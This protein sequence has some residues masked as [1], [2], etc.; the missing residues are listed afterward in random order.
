MIVKK[1]HHNSSGFGIIEILVVAVIISLVLVGLHSAAVQ[2]LRLIHQSTQRT[3]ATFLLEETVEVLR[4]LRD[5]GWSTSL[6]TLSTGTDYFLSF[7]G[8][9]WTV[10]TTKTLIDNV[11]ERKFTVEDIYRDANDDIATTGTLDPD[12][13]KITVTVLWGSITGES[14]VVAYETGTTDTDLANFPDNSGWGD[15]LQSFTTPAGSDSIVPRAELFIKRATADPS[16]IYLEIRSGG[17]QGSVLATSNTIDSATLPSSLGWTSFTFATPPTLSPSAM[18][19]LRPRSIPDSAIVASG[20]QP[21]VHWGYGWPSSYA[22][23]DAYRYVGQSDNG[24][25]LTGYDFSFRVYKQTT[26]TG[27]NSVQVIT[28]LTDMF[29]N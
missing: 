22:S 25:T 26:T 1:L 24:E 13:K 8:G 6:A 3:Q 5:V 27:G 10:T 21:R 20:A 2:S 19:Y 23:G 11:F 16:D 17:V 14:V 18:Y 15:P 4:S 29:D 9:A 12:T 7:S 28:Y